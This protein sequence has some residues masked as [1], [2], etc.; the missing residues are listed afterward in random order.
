[1]HEILLGG[2]Q[3][4]CARARGAMAVRGTHDN[5]KDGLKA[6]V[7]VSEDWHTRLTLMKVHVM[8]IVASSFAAAFIVCLSH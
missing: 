4:T 7:P 6:V 2:D 8:Y 5:A 3:L 1:M